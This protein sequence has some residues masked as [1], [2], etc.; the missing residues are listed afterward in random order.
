MWL[1]WCFHQLSL[2]LSISLSHLH[3]LCLSLSRSLALCLSLSLSLSRAWRRTKQANL[4]MWMNGGWATS[5]EH[6]S[7]QKKNALHSSST[8]SSHVFT[9]P[10]APVRLFINELLLPTLGKN[11]VSPE[12]VP[13]MAHVKKSQSKARRASSLLDSHPNRMPELW[14]H[15][16]CI[17]SC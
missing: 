5:S 9:Q 8:S 13:R 1:T 17:S 16:C 14:Q 15:L 10:R 7:T 12:D 3:Q 2:S 11:K 4:A 6:P